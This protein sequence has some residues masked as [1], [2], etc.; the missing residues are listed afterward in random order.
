MLIDGRCRDITKSCHHLLRQPDI[1]VLVAHLHAFRAIAGGGGKGQVFRRAGA[2]RMLWYMW[3]GTV[4]PSFFQSDSILLQQPLRLSLTRGGDLS[5][6]GAS[7]VTNRPVLCQF[8]QD[9]EIAS[10]PAPADKGALP[11]FFLLYRPESRRVMLLPRGQV[12]QHKRQFPDS[13]CLPICHPVPPPFS[14][15]DVTIPYGGH[16]VHSMSAGFPHETQRAAVS[17][18]SANDLCQGL[19]VVWKFPIDRRYGCQLTR[20]TATC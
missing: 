16:P 20:I 7:A 12:H 5:G 8:I 3:S 18:G 13:F 4:T 19:Q 6:P 15:I 11:Q 2:D 10:F 17:N 9:L 14:A 1:F